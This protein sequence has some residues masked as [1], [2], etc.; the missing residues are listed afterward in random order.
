M[1]TCHLAGLTAL[2]HLREVFGFW[3]WA[4]VPISV[5]HSGGFWSGLEFL[6][7]A[8]KQPSSLA[9]YKLKGLKTF[10]SS[11]ERML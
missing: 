11:Y 3:F 1:C 6:V 8:R 2:C 7:S 10:Y 5:L 9:T 4:R